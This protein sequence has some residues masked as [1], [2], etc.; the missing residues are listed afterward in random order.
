MFWP[1]YVVDDFPGARVLLFNYD[2]KI[3]T[4]FGV[5]DIEKMASNL[6][7]VLGNARQGDYG[8]K[9]IIFI[10]HSLAGFLLKAVRCHVSS[11]PNLPY[12]SPNTL[13]GVY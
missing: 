5:E 7:R 10:A 9:P 13:I 4:H 2:T 1:G 8:G 3:W 6:V 12:F 11:P